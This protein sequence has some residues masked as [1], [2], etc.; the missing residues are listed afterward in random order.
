MYIYIYV[1][2]YIYIYI[3]MYIYI[4]TQKEALLCFAKLR[5]MELLR[6][7][8]MPSKRGHEQICNKFKNHAQVG[9]R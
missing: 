8:K 5:S 3:Y 9:E 6:S 4:Y 2:I 7:Y 1:Y